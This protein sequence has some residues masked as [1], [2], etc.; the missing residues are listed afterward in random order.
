M[1]AFLLPSAATMAPLSLI[2]ATDAFERF[3]CLLP[4]CCFVV[5]FDATRQRAVY[6]FAMLR[7][8]AVTRLRQLCASQWRQEAAKQRS[9][10]VCLRDAAM[11]CCHASDIFIDMPM[12]AARGAMFAADVYAPEICCDATRL[13][14]PMLYAAAVT[15]TLRLFAAIT[16]LTMPMM[17]LRLIFA[18]LPPAA[19]FAMA[20]LFFAMPTLSPMLFPDAA[21][22]FAIS[23]CLY[24]FHA[25]ADIRFRFTEDAAA[26]FA[27]VD[28]AP[29]VS[30]TRRLMLTMPAL[31]RC[32]RYAAMSA[33][34]LL[35]MLMP[36]PYE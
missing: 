34:G 19:R 10:D 16:M 1:L 21:G 23:P 6:F 5:T 8:C 14:L 12:S 35:M 15:A 17:P 22:H 11:L 27:A 18:M 29:V 26:I 28:A 25:Y 2:D 9:K 32:C 31:P 4:R 20:C 3:R 33:E 30:A 24:D 36:P 13:E 7:G